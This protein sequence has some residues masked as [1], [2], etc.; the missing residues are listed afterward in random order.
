M[1]ATENPAFG[2]YGTWEN[3]HP[4]CV[5]MGLDTS[6]QT[7][8]I[9]LL[10]ASICFCQVLFMAS[11]APRVT[12]EAVYLPLVETV[13]YGMA[14]SGN[15]NLRISNGR[16]VP[17]ARFC[18]WLITC[19]IMLLQVVVMHDVVWFNVS[20]RYMVLAA[21]LIRTVFGIGASVTTNDTMRWVQFLLSC[22]CFAFEMVVAHQTYKGALKKF[23]AVKTTLNGVVY[24]RI[25]F[26]R[27]LFFFSWNAFPIIW[28]LSSTGLCLISEDASVLSYLVADLICKNIYGITNANT[29][30][31]VL[32]G[33]WVPETEEHAQAKDHLTYLEMMMNHNLGIG[34]HHDE[35]LQMEVGHDVESAPRTPALKNVRVDLDAQSA[36][37]VRDTLSGKGVGPLSPLSPGIAPVSPNPPLPDRNS[38]DSAGSGASGVPERGVSQASEFRVMALQHGPRSSSSPHPAAAIPQ[39]VPSLSSSLFEVDSPAR[40]SRRL[41]QP[42]LA[43]GVAHDDLVE[44]ARRVVAQ[45]DAREAAKRRVPPMVEATL[46][47]PE[48]RG[49]PR[50]RSAEPGGRLPRSLEAALLQDLR[51]RSRENSVQPAS[52]VA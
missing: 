27:F 46:I 51:A 8:M 12:W 45:A 16:M 6:S 19:P 15:G 14:A 34:R 24:A 52:R 3:D 44:F 33:A 2:L 18:S 43:L 47:Q 25:M 22:I 7:N 40:A 26:L 42:G 20:T 13:L 23:A 1:S 29:V 10:F 28:A 39:R 4:Q 36:S 38:D 30:F 50:E 37:S 21:S 35:E 11:R 48:E 41:S 49:R 5:E 9:H 17:M 32:D 31:R